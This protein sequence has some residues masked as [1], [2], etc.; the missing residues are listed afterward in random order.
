MIIEREPAM[1][2]AI[3]ERITLFVHI[4][5]IIFDESW[6]VFPDTRDNCIIFILKKIILFGYEKKIKIFS[7]KKY[8]YFLFKKN[9]FRLLRK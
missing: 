7:V 4:G 6:N 5:G 1:I 2:I 8:L 9:Y 3:V